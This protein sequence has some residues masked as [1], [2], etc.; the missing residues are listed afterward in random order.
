MSVTI[1][2]IEPIQVA[3]MRHIGPYE[4]LD[5]HWAKFFVWVIQNDIDFD[6][7]R[8]IGIAHDNP[9]ITPHDELRFDA[10]VSVDKQFQLSGEVELQEIEGGD[11]AIL[12]HQGPY[13]GLSERMNWLFNE[14][15]PGSGRELRGD[16]CFMDYRNS[17]M[18]TPQEKLL[19]D[20]YLPLGK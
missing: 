9:H 5:Q 4:E 3:Y 16:P 14:W 19:T 13:E 20:I 10:C 18:N 8:V 17:P 6:N 15:L 12:T 2:T 7:A 1:K 11:Y